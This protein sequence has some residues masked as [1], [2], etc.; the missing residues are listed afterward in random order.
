MKLTNS[1]PVHTLQADITPE[2]VAHVQH[3]YETQDRE[4]KAS[5]PHGGLFH[6]GH[7]QHVHAEQ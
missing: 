4:R 1:G 6:H 3:E 7:S 5:H 2:M